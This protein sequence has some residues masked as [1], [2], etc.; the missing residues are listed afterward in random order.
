M[1]KTDKQPTLDELYYELVHLHG[2]IEGLAF[3]D[4]E[5][6]GPSDLRIDN[7]IC[8]LIMHIERI[9]GRAMLMADELASA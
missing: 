4:N 6:S 8:S 9:A 5:N 1:S 7:A 2:L 3:L